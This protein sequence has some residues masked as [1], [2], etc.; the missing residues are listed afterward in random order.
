MINLLQSLGLILQFDYQWAHQ[1][2]HLDIKICLI[3][4]QLA[5]N[6]ILGVINNIKRRWFKNNQNLKEIIINLGLRGSI[7]Q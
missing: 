4:Q 1:T 6:I 7:N 3:H 2:Q 5:H